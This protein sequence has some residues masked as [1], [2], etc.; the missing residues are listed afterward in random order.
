LAR[1]Y[2]NRK[3]LFPSVGVIG[4]RDGWFPS[5]KLKMV[6]EEKRRSVCLVALVAHLTLKP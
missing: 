1:D 2:K 6:R 5:I 3:E 4:R